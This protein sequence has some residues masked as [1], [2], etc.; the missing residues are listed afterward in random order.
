[1]S[2]SMSVNAASNVLHVARMAMQSRVDQI[3][4]QSSQ[5]VS[6]GADRENDGDADDRA[7]VTSTRGQ[8]LNISA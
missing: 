8:N 2:N 7:S 3:Q 6:D 1:M 5:A 4:N